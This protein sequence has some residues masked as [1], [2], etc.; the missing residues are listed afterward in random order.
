MLL[1]ALHPCL[2]AGG[3]L[4]GNVQQE[5]HV[6]GHGLP[7]VKG[8]GKGQFRGRSKTHRMSAPEKP[9]VAWAST[10]SSI[11]AM[12]LSFASR[13]MICNRAASSGGGTKM[14]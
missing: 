11:F 5:I 13:R 9:A 1:H 10:A 3:V 7:G 12:G 8:I 4:P 6:D 2:S 14:A